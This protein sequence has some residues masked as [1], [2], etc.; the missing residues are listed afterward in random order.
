MKVFDVVVNPFVSSYI[1]G[2]PNPMHKSMIIHIG[3]EYTKTLRIDGE[4]TT[5]YTEDVKLWDVSHSIDIKNLI[6][7]GG[8]E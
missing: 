1:N 7:R 2:K 5:Y 3:S 6:L 4:V 8:I